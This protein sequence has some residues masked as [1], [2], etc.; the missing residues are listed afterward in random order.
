MTEKIDKNFFP[1]PN[2]R[3]LSAIFDFFIGLFLLVALSVYL[4]TFFYITYPSVSEFIVLYYFVIPYLT[5][6]Q[7]LGQY[8]FR[9]KTVS[10]ISS[11]LT[12]YQICARQA[13]FWFGLKDMG[14][15][16][17]NQQLHDK[18]FYTTII[19]ANKY[20]EFNSLNIRKVPKVIF[21]FGS[22][23]LTVFVLVFFLYKGLY[24]VI[25]IP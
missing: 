19:K 23:F 20:G 2:I 5:N 14:E 24:D 16:N 4:N 18:L 6:G 3:I 8:I 9:I 11:K 1:N 15:V 21:K 17:N 12:F 25:I 10:L 22:I 7:T 13:T